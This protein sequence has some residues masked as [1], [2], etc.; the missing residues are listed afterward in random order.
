MSNVP[1]EI[2]EIL[3]P[4]GFRE[5]ARVTLLGKTIEKYTGR[6]RNIIVWKICVN[7]ML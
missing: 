2:G 3:V 4:F 6:N 7:Y 1:S 5:V